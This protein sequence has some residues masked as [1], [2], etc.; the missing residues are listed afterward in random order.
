MRIFKSSRAVLALNGIVMMLTGASFFVFAEKITIL[1][2]PDVNLNPQA[3]E[4]G[5]VLRYLMGA[6]SMS[7]GIILYLARVSIKSGA[8]RLLLGCGLG[9]IIIF[10]TGIFVM[11]KHEANIPLVALSVYPVLATL[12]LYVANRK[13]QE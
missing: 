13:F 9:F 12:S 8:Q 4:V 10:A 1:M 6:G 7:I 2:F 11:I 3:L 5:I